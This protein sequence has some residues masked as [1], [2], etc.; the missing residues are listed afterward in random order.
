MQADFLFQNH[1][2]VCLLQPLTPAGESWFNEH[3]PID[4]PEAQFFGDS[5]VIEPRYVPDI[6]AGIVNDGLRVTT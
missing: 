4:S 2:S 5:M 6:L 3:L 1:G